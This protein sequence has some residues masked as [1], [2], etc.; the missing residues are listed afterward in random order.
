MLL[1]SPARRVGC[2]GHRGRGPTPAVSPRQSP[3]PPDP[4]PRTQKNPG[5]PHPRQGSCCSWEDRVGWGRVRWG[6][7][8]CRSSSAG[9]TT[10]AGRRRKKRNRN[11]PHHYRSDQWSNHT[12]LPLSLPLALVLMHR[13]HRSP[14]A[15]HTHRCSLGLDRRRRMVARRAR[16]GCLRWTMCPGAQSAR[17]SHRPSSPPIQPT[18]EIEQ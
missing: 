9:P 18:T 2:T 13:S 10:K 7:V 15:L 3:P 14:L 12:A 8:H 5:P 17:P 11:H 4:P 1:M 6:W 16:G